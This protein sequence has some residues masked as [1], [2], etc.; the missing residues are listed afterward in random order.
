M[1]DIDYFKT[2]ND[3]YGHPQ[4]DECLRDVARVLED[5]PRRGYDLVARYG[6][7]EF[8][9]L[10]P[11]AEAADAAM[12]AETIRQSVEEL[13]FENLGSAVAGVVTVS[14]GVCGR[15]PQIADDPDCLVACADAAL[16]AAKRLGKNRV[17]MA[18]DQVVA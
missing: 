9:V 11:E 5:Q 4:G 16:Y 8:A 10:L 17:E 7:E 15:K 3:R 18:L 12:I 13:G 6:G 2:L 14:I 1:I